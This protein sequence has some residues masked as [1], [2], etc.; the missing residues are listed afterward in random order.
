MQ[1]NGRGEGAQG[2]W[3]RQIRHKK[4]EGRR[5]GRVQSQGLLLSTESDPGA[6]YFPPRP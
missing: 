2:E 4:W 5:G 6:E 1:P 3:G